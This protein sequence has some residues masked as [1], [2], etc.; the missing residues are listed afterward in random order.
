MTKH[1]FLYDVS[2]VHKTTTVCKRI[3][4]VRGVCVCGGGEAS[5]QIIRGLNLLS[6]PR[7]KTSYPLKLL[8]GH[9]YG[10]SFI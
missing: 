8:S 1:A 4:L 10:K 3:S 9:F 5:L 2:N 7:K 6:F